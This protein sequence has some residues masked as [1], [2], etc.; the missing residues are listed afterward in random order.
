MTGQRE[1]GKLSPYKQ[2]KPPLRGVTHFKSAYVPFYIYFASNK[3]FICFTIS[4]SVEFFPQGRQGLKSCL[5]HFTP[6]SPLR[7]PRAP[8]SGCFPNYTITAISSDS[9]LRVHLLTQESFHR[10]KAETRKSR[11]FPEV[12]TIDSET[13]GS[14]ISLQGD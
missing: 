2:A 11:S 12:E 8:G 6:H 1:P 7:S 14:S 10:I 13:L 9:P 5:S 4:V 3:C